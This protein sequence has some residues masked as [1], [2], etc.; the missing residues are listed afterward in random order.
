MDEDEAKIVREIFE[1]YSHGERAVDIIQDLNNRRIK[2]S[3]GREFNKNSLHR[4]LRNRRYIGYYT[5]DGI[6][7]PN[8]MPRIVDD[9]IF[10]KVQDMLTSNRAHA[11]KGKAKDDYLLTTKLFCGHCGDPMIGYCGTGK[12]GKVYHYYSCTGNRKKTCKKKIVAKD[13][14]EG[15]VADIC[16]Q[17]LTPERIQI[18]AEEVIKACQAGGEY[19]SIKKLREAIKEADLA[20]ENLWV[21]LEKGQSP[22]RITKRIQQRE[23]EKEA[24]E[25]QL[26]KEKRKQPTLQLTHVLSFLNYL[27][28]LA[29]TDKV[30][31][32]T[33][34]TIFINS[35]YLY[36]DYFTIIFNAGNATLRV[37][38]IPRESIENSL[39][40]AVNNTSWSS[41]SIGSVPPDIDSFRQKTVDFLF[42]DRFNLAFCT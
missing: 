31:R 4:L 2:T 1:R 9:D 15:Q 27:R 29:G 42:I 20:I 21:A 22:E 28:D 34:I 8:G 11:G 13:L 18:I 39:K 30:K 19:L 14:I 25:K 41:V 3:I 10:Y 32:K 24:L 33:L 5:Y 35:V 26:A 36:D 16:A 23:A 38:N 40:E 12:M 6:E 7:T 17:L 37:E